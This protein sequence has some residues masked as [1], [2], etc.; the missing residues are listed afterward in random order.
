MKKFVLKDDF[1]ELFPEAQIGILVCRGIDNHVKEE[2]KYA[3]WLR[4]CEKASRRG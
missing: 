1:L 4:E 2:D 3:P